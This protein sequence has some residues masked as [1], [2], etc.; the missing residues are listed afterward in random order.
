MTK[1]Q[2]RITYRTAFEIDR[3]M[4]R[5]FWNSNLEFSSDFEIR[6]SDL[7]CR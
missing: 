3:L 1:I 5:K 7:I 2:N 4:F 6:I